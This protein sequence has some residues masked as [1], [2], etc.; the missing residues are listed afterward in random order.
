MLESVIEAGAIREAKKSGWW[1]IKL[2]PTI[3]AGLPD[4]IAIGQG[5]VV[6]LEFKTEKGKL[7]KLQKA[8]HR[9]FASH[10]IEVHVVRSKEETMGVLNG[11]K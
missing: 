6:F 7:T 9:K 2:M 10:G 5:R 8:I 11:Q 3:I 4:R 1:L